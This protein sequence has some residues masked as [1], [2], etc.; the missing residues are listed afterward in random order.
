MAGA[1]VEKLGRISRLFTGAR[2]RFGIPTDVQ[3]AD[4]FMDKGFNAVATV[5]CS[6]TA[7]FDAIWRDRSEAGDMTY[8][9]VPNEHAIV[10][11]TSGIY[12]GTG[13]LALGHMQNSG[14]MN[15]ADA[16]ISF[17]SV[18]KVPTFAIVTWRGN[19]LK[20]DS[21][22]HQEIGRRT[23][24]LTKAVAGEKSVFGGRGGRGILREVNKA[25]EWA[26]SG[27]VALLRL[28]PY[29]FISTYPLEVKLPDEEDSP[30]R[31]ERLEEI[32]A[33]KGL[34]YD[35]VRS[36]IP[37]SRNEAISQILE[38]H[39][40]AARI[41]SNGYTARAA[42]FANDEMGNF[43]NVGYMGGGLA[44]GYGMAISNPRLE[45]VVVDGDQNAQMGLMDRVIENNYPPNLH[46]YI[47]DNR[48]G[49]SVGV[50]V[51]N[52]LT[53]SFYHLARVV[54][55]TPDQPRT[56]KDP[57]VGAR[58]VYFETDEAKALAEEIGPLP[59]HLRRFRN[60]VDSQAG[61]K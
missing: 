3:L 60:W 9:R 2:E 1:D 7:S 30:S 32:R 27:N 8:V 54:R 49:A 25:L 37:I 22:P 18:Y 53:E 15:A 16:I 4:F 33:T 20:D 13:K 12:M 40:D 41:F 21:E 35:D 45:V 19:D 34:P 42:Q 31:Y 38:E 23:Q 24:Q 47:L 6:I 28:S 58:G 56:F 11:V 46:W 50:A 29:A 39:P 36:R 61:K 44:I 57:R 52:P 55:T 43:Y 51:S 5:P 14:L 10:G 17:A 48:I 26:Q 59:T